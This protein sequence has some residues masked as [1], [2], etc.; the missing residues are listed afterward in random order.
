MTAERWTDVDDT[1]EN[2]FLLD[3]PGLHF[4]RERGAGAAYLFHLGRQRPQGAA[5]PAG[6]HAPIRQ[7]QRGLCG[8][9]RKRPRFFAGHAAW[10]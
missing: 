5:N 8:A 4:R 2:P 10:H 1:I 3:I 7:A 9:T 6:K